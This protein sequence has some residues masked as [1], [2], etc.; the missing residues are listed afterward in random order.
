MNRSIEALA[1]AA[2]EED[3]GQ[4]D[5]TTLATVAANARCEVRL[6]A[7]QAGVLS[8]IDIFRTTF[9]LLD[10]RIEDWNARLDGERFEAGDLLV[11]FSGMT[12]QILTAERTA[13]NFTQHLSGIATLTAAYCD[14]IE[15]LRCRICDTR[16]TTPL[17][18]RLEK[19]AVVHGGGVNH[20]FNLSSG[21][22]I[23]ENHITSVGGVA[24][25]LYRAKAHASHLI[26]VEIEVTSLEDFDI[27]LATGAEII[28]LD[29]MSLADMKEAVKRR[30]NAPVLLEASGNASLER[31]RAM[32]E[33]GVDLISVGALT[34]SAPA[35]DMTLLIDNA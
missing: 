33:T 18:R 32:A 1:A 15:G 22:L 16:K 35:V 29:N 13:M 4:G 31:I 10:S 34:H 19:A 6:L 17:L 2:L 21:I 12:R 8:G 24:E 9:E 27:A 11:S 5:L 28:L 20:R 3:M 23:K 14:A 25:A 30:A 7:K 26:R